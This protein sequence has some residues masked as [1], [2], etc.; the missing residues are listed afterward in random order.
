MRPFLSRKEMI[1]M[2]INKRVRSNVARNIRRQ[3]DRRIARTERIKAQ[4]EEGSALYTSYE[5]KIS[6]LQEAKNNTYATSR[7]EEGKRIIKSDQEITIGLQEASK[8]LVRSRYLTERGLRNMTSTQMQLNAGS[9]E[10]VS[11]YTQAEVKIFFRATQRAWDR[12]GVSVKERI[13]AIM[14]FYGY[15]NLSEL[16]S[17]ILTLNQEAVRKSEKFYKEKGTKEQEDFQTEQDV[18]E[19]QQSPTYL[20]DVIPMAEPSGLRELEKA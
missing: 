18:K 3:I 15:E 17:D 16:V 10:S 2:A 1:H 11:E 8:E 20:A 19:A 4:Y 5:K 9:V 13:P 12:E 14:E 6:Q 7:T